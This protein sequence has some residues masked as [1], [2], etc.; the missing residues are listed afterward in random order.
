M[1]E[2][3][4]GHQNP[5]FTMDETDKKSNEESRCVEIT[6]EIKKRSKWNNEIEFLM[7]CI[8][9][10][11]GFGNIW[12]FPFTA[13][14]NGGGVFL[15]PYIIV[16]F[17]V[18]KPIYYME[19]ILGQFSS[20]SSI[21]VW[22]ISPGFSGIG[23]SQFYCNT[24]LMTYYSSLMAL[25]LFFLI[26]SFSAELPW[27]KCREE[28]LDYCIDSSHQIDNN[29]SN[30]TSFV[31]L[32]NEK[33][34]R[35]SA[36]LYFLKVVL[37]EKDSI[38]DGI[39]LPSWKL[40][41][42]LL[43]SWISVILITSQGVKSSGKASYFLAI[44]PYIILFSLL[45]RA[46]TLDG[47]ATGILFF[48][49]PKWSKL[50][51]P[52]V[53]YAAITQ[54]FF[55]LSVCFGPILTYSS[56]NDFKH[57]LY[58]DVLIVTTLDTFTSFIAGCTI[59]GIL[60]N[61][62]HKMGL[63]D[64]SKVVKSG[65][66]LAFVSYPD[67]IAKFNVVPQLFAVLFF[68]M[69]FVL[70]V[71]SIVGM[72]SGLAH[73][74]KEKLPNVQIWKIVLCICSMSFAA[75]TIYVTPVR[76]GQFLLNLVDYY[77]TSF[78]VFFVASFEITAI[79]WVY[80]LIVTFTYTLKLKRSIIFLQTGIEN[81]L[82]DVEFMLDRKTGSYWRIC[83]FLVTPLILLFIFFY[84]FATLQLLT[85][86]KKEYPISAHAAGIVVSCL[87]IFQIPFWMIVKLLKNRNLPLS[88]FGFFFVEYKKVFSAN[89][90]MGAKGYRAQ[91]GLAS[92]QRGEREA[93][94]SQ[95]EAKMGS[96]DTHFD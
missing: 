42:C 20:S 49:T 19:I 25:T 17:L 13:Y 26:A 62:A 91:K 46:V 71:G 11:I 93:E 94:K 83:W 59:F 33:E 37:Q 51:E 82:N 77:G 75:S 65:V 52:S 24:A 88:K 50:F 14:E 6:R 1:A 40:T 12:R 45:I 5:T 63:E 38:D 32:L 7:S 95:K 85:Y 55:S 79:M 22:N 31:Q 80:E 89:L 27:A 10:S 21:N 76:G 68:V 61:L 44:F 66:G 8:A 36:E 34:R 29:T 28:W 57:N 47:A 54:C 41:L 64:I 23:W 96:I 70:G 43:V 9:I 56:H 90:A 48:V 2:N 35:S 87:G 58:R 81:F 30:I 18:G 84:T 69:M 16:L 78:V 86:G 72:V 60:G 15:I 74:L 53:W 73:S 39:G 3:D 4:R 92:I 67:A